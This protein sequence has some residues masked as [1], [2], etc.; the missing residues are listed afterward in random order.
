MRPSDPHR[1]PLFDELMAQA[2]WMRK[3]AHSLV[4]DPNEAEDVVQEAWVVAL[5]E[6]AAVRVDLG[7]WLRTVVRNLALRRSSR[8]RRRPAIE[9]RAA[10]DEAAEVDAPAAIER[11]ELQRWLAEA[12]LAL[13]EP[14]RTAVI[15]RHLEG[16][17]AS[18]IGRA[19][20]CTP[21]AARQRVARG[22]ERLRK[23]LDAEQ[24]G[25]ERWALLL[26]PYATGAAR[27]GSP[28]MSTS[29]ITTAG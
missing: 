14:Y 16:L 11:M 29:T 17:D 21:E 1:P 3:L 15:L 23:R 12:L 24:G 7:S 19:Q 5:R 9:E 8:E 13:D 28:T 2:G 22:L 4:A 27:I 6:R 26:A 10:R 25:R 18:A 20:G